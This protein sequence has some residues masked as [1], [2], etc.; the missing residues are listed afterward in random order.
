MILLAYIAAVLLCG[1]AAFQFALAFGAPFGEFT[2][3]GKQP[4]L[5]RKERYASAVSGVALLV[6]LAY[7][8]SAAGASLLVREPVLS[9]GLWIITIYLALNT[10]ANA[11]SKSKKERLVMAPL[12]FVLF[13]IF[14]FFAIA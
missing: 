6:M 13:A 8:L 14:L 11:S 10:L 7:V 1:L 4:V 9:I 5:T 2:Q 12:S 3:G